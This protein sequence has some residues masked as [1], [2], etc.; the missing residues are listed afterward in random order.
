MSFAKALIEQGFR[1]DL[2]LAKDRSCGRPLVDGI[3]EKHNQ[4]ST[5]AV[6]AISESQA[7]AAMI[8]MRTCSRWP[9]STPRS[10][11]IRML[12][13]QSKSELD[14]P[15]ATGASGSEK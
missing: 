2:F 12:P 1:L 4:P 6:R 10:N 5:W 14:T 13:R 11:T 7:E 15:R 3:S 9:V 8:L